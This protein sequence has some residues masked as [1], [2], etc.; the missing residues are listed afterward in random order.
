METEEEEEAYLL[1]DDGVDGRLFHPDA[2]VELGADG[3]G[4]GVSDRVVRRVA[5]RV[6]QPEMLPEEGAAQ[7]PGVTAGGVRPAGHARRVRPCVL[8]QRGEL[9]VASAQHAAVVDVGGA[10][11]HVCVVDDQQL[12]VNVDEFGRLKHAMFRSS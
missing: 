11:D 7:R 4:D 3:V 2:L 10:A 8:H 9:A 5:R 12:A 1:V 6:Q